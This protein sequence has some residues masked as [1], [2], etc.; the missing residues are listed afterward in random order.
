M[1]LDLSGFI[2]KKTEIELGSEL[3]TFTELSLKDL[4]EF[5][6]EVTRKREEYNQK[7]RQR[8]LEDAKQCGAIDPLKLLEHL[9]KPLTE[10]EIDAEMETT[11]GMGLLVYYSLRYAHA[12]ISKEQAMQIVTPSRIPEITK[13]LFPQSSNEKSEE[14]DNKKKQTETVGQKQ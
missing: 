4:A 6:A 2:P 7:R 8:I 3:F 5:R 1:A 9:D 13:A 12:G 10:D 11:Y 14:K